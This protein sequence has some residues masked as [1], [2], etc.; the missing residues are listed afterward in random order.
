VWRFLNLQAD[1]SIDANDVFTRLM[2]DD[3]KPR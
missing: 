3:L 2:G 1:D